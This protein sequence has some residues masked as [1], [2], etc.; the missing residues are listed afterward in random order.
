LNQKA[1]GY[2]NLLITLVF[3]ST[4][5]VISKTLVGRMDSFTIN[6]IRFFIGGLILF[7]ITLIKRDI[8]IEFKDFIWLIVIGIISVTISMNLLQFS[9]Y[10]PGA[11]A[12]VAAVIF[13][14]NPVFVCIFASMIEK[15]KINLYKLLGL[16]IAI[17]GIFVIFYEKLQ[18]GVNDFISPLLVLLSALFYGLYTVM[19][20]KVSVKIGSLKMNA[21][22]FI[23]GSLVSLPILFLTGLPAVTLDSDV[24]I[25]LVYLSVFVS[26]LAYLAYFKGLSI[27]G[28][29]NGSLVFFLKPVLS[30]FIAV[31]F[32]SEKMSLYLFAGT[33]LIII[34]VIVVLR[35]GN[36]AGKVLKKL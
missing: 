18:G 35:F 36:H 21:Y 26:G 10:L 24:I 13:S 8:K 5:E 28:S 2:L 15:E 6:F 4:F 27:L 11:K 32:L 19:G 22:T 29:T 3:F 33:V 14:S 7:I 9:L 16:I 1:F 23:T 25:K 31:W 30:S 34:G 12:S 17:S 20:R